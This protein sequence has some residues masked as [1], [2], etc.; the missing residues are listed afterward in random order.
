MTQFEI[1]FY[2]G[3]GRVQQTLDDTQKML[4]EMEMSA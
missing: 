4:D 2:K 3:L 1:E